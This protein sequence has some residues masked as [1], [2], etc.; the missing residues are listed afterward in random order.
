MKKIEDC[1]I[2]IETKTSGYHTKISVVFDE[3]QT[4]EML[5]SAPLLKSKFNEENFIQS[6]I[7]F[8]IKG[9]KW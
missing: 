2:R 6:I 7:N 1:K 8:F 3:M 9:G 4:Y 5:L